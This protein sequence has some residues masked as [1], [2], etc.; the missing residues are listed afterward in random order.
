MSMHLQ[1]GLSSLNTR[2]RKPKKYTKAQLREWSE[3]LFLE[4][5]ERKR[6][7]Q[8]EITLN[9]YIDRVYGRKQ[10][11][12]PEFKP[13]QKRVNPLIEERMQAYRALPSAEVETGAD[14]CA[15]PDT[16]YKVEASKNYT[17]AP[18]YNK[19]GYTVIPRDEVKHIGRK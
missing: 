2:K 9:A 14:A 10:M 11:P 3:E 19:A 17:V 16:A 7:G 1:R 18:A 6:R 5:R 15:L 4:N 13:L 12:E 8:P